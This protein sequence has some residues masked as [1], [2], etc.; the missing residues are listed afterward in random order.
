M[1]GDWIKMRSNLRD[2]PDVI[3]LAGRIE[4]DEF[5]IVGKLHAVWVWLDQH[6]E[7][8]TNVRITSAYLDRL[9]ACP[10]FADAMRT[11][12]WLDG[13]DGAL[14]FPR[15]DRHNGD[16][17]KTRA[18]EAKRKAK[19]RETPKTPPELDGTNVPEVVPENTGQE[20][21]RVEKIDKKGTAQAPA[22]GA[23]TS[24]PVP[25]SLAGIS[26][27]PAEW[28]EF[29][30]HRRKKRDP[31]TP[32][33]EDLILRILAE[34]PALAVRAIQEAIQ[35]GWKAIRWDWLENRDPKV[36]CGHGKLNGKPRDRMTVLRDCAG[37]YGFQ[38]GEYVRGHESF[39]DGEDDISK[40]RE[41]M[42]VKFLHHK[43]EKA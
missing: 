18:T 27:F 19:Y 25:E 11:V 24:S 33:A 36:F 3:L 32:H 43:G 40:A 5:S 30:A 20:K 41:S 9:T 7:D 16:S 12:G 29:R 4:T 21:R 2:D 34:R 13:R 15:F 1:A 10:G 26:G 6:S 38:F 39:P 22:A 28:D 8:G 42:L 37:K 31:M 14:I 35:A 17:A 23:A